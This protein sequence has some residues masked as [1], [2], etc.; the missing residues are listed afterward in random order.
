MKRF[1]PSHLLSLVFLAL[2]VYVLGRVVD[3]RHRPFEASGPFLGLPTA[4][5]D[6]PA[7]PGSPGEPGFGESGYGESG[8]GES[9]GGGGESGCESGSCG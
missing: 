2:L 5:A 6:A 8:C 3:S 7:S 4:F 1:R 9:A